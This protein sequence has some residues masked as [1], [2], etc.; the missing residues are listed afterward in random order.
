M[1]SV[2]RD[3]AAVDLALA[4]VRP[5]S[6]KLVTG[7]ERPDVLLPVAGGLGIHR[8]DDLCAVPAVAGPMRDPGFRPAETMRRTFRIV[9][10]VPG[11]ADEDQ[12]AADVA[13][14]KFGIAATAVV[15]RL[16][17]RGG[18]SAA[19][20]GEDSHG[21]FHREVCGL[22]KVSGVEAEAFSDFFELRPQ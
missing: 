18:K 19:R 9:A 7:L 15:E 4:P 1:A 13:G 21:D 20:V 16:S 8:T 17:G 2:S 10:F 6:R 3:N 12:L 5:P 14:R 22:A 11:I